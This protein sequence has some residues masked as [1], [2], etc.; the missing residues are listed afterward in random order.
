[1]KNLPELPKNAIE[2]YNLKRAGGM[3]ARLLDPTM[4]SMPENQVRHE[5]VWEKDAAF[6]FGT[7]NRIR[8]HKY[9]GELYIKSYRKFKGQSRVRWSHP[10]DVEAGIRQ[11]D[12][13]REAYDP[14]TGNEVEKTKHVIELVRDL[15]HYFQQPGLTLL[16]FGLAA[17]QAAD[18]LV[19][20]GFVDAV[21]EERQDVVDKIMKAA[22]L[23]SLSRPNA[24]RSRMILSHV[25]VDLIH[26]LLVHKMTENKYANIQAKLIREREYERFVLGQTVLHIEE[27]IRASTGFEDRRSV[28]ELKQFVNQY[29]GPDVVKLKPYAK[30]AATARFLIMNTGTK[31][32]LEALRKYIGDEADMYYATPTLVQTDKVRRLTQI[33]KD[34]S[35]GLE[36]GDL[37]LVTPVEEREDA[38]EKYYATHKAG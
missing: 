16:D 11:A 8:Y 27:Q 37:F 13:V 38:L 23:D 20:T 33:K 34:I 32:E 7:D 21:K 25:W 10:V 24:S 3:Q 15:S 1:M 28:L 17:T 19:Q 6:L 2:R 9:H 36:I 22:S 5:E 14:K 29:L 35:Q 30:K 12:H 26:E 31:E 18:T 4:V